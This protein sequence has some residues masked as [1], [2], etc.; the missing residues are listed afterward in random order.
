MVILKIKS[1]L[2]ESPLR[3][4]LDLTLH[5]G[6]RLKL[7]TKVAKR[8]AKSQK[9]A[10]QRKGMLYESTFMII[11]NNFAEIAQRRKPK[12]RKVAEGR[13]KSRN[14]ADGILSYNLQVE[15]RPFVVM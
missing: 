1:R 12:S 10:E 7:R 5:A 11:S 6:S 14:V 9:V 13:T 2:C 4:I 8:R 3:P 15:D